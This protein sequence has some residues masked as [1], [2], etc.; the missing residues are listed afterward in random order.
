LYLGNGPGADGFLME[1]NHPNLSAQQYQLYEQMGEISYTAWRGRL[2]SQ[3]IRADVP[4]FLRLCLIRAYFFWFG[5]PN[6]AGHPFNDAGRALNYGLSS[7]AGLLGLALALR[8]R[9]PAA[10]LFAAVFLLQPT[11]YYIV[12]AHARFRHPLEPL[13][14]VLGVYLFQQA[15]RKWGFTLPGL[16]RLWPA[17]WSRL[18]FSL[19]NRYT[20]LVWRFLPVAVEPRRSPAIRG[21]SASVPRTGSFPPEQFDSGAH[22]P[23]RELALEGLCTL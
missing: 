16:R 2:A 14:T 1:Y 3:L 12:T 22:P 19:Q 21:L 6:P 9:L 18:T 11:V 23:R 8:R 17:Q 10:G 20:T 13:I 15:E 7:L 5:V 4:R